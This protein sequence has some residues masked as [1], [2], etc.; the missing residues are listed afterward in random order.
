MII[1]VTFIILVLI[2]FITHKSNK[3]NIAENP[4]YR[5]IFFWQDENKAYS[6]LLHS[7]TI[8]DN[9]FSAYSTKW[10]SLMTFSAHPSDLKLIK[11]KLTNIFY[12]PQKC[13]NCHID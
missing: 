13:L 9:S 7:V 4:N 12:S 11:K 1:L 10:D 6:L 3:D 5:E 8:Y 2:I